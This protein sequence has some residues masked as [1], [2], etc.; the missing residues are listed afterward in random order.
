LFPPYLSGFP[1]LCLYRKLVE[2]FLPKVGASKKLI[3]DM[4]FGNIVKTFS[5]KLGGVI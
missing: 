4:T 1:S 2:D 3:D 5:S